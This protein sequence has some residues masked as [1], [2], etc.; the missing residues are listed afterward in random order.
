[1]K[2]F[3]NRS[4]FLIA[5]GIIFTSF[6]QNYYENSEVKI[7]CSGKCASGEKCSLQGNINEEKGIQTITCTCSNC[8]MIVESTIEEKKLTTTLVNSTFEVNHFNLFQE[9]MSKE[10]T[11]QEYKLNEVEIIKNDKNIVETYHFNVNGK[12]ESVMYSS[13]IE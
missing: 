6:T 10:Y 11:N 7:S 13:K 12:V 4:V 3:I 2:K 8:K 1:M 9:F 5:I